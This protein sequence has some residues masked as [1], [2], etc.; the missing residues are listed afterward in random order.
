LLLTRRPF[1]LG[2]AQSIVHRSFQRY[3]AAD[4]ETEVWLNPFVLWRVRLMKRK[5]I[6]LAVGMIAALSFAARLH[7]QTILGDGDGDD[8]EDT[9]TVVGGE[10]VF[11][12]ED[13]VYDPEGGAWL[14]Y[15]EIPF[16]PDTDFPNGIPAG[17]VISVHESILISPNSPGIT[18][19]HEIVLPDSIDF[20]SGFEQQGADTAEWVVDS[21]MAMFESQDVL[22]EAEYDGVNVDLFFDYPLSGGTLE[23]WKDY[24]TTADVP[25]FHPL[26]TNMTDPG[27]FAYQLIIEYPTHDVPEPATCTLVLLSS[28]F[29]VPWAR[30]RLR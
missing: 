14:K 29:V 3:Y 16:G 27:G 28:L 11:E 5:A 22:A 15:T 4:G 9:Q 17:T 26:D 10:V 6:Y 20:N 2:L 1:I 25:L 13:V 12:I 18:D 24:I 30:R 8:V 21:A 19:W 23:I 7:A